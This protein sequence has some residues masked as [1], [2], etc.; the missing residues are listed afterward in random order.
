MTFYLKIPFIF[1]IFVFTL[2]MQNTKAQEIAVTLRGDSIV[3]FANGTW[4]FLDNYQRGLGNA[5]EDIPFND[6]I[7]TTPSKSTRK[8]NGF[9]NLYE[10]W[11]DNNKWQRLTPAEINAEADIALKLLDGDVYAMILF[12]EMEIPVEN[13]ANIAVSNAVAAAPDVVVTGKEYRKVNDNTVIWMRMEG[14]PQGMKIVYYSY[15]CSNSK[16]SLQFV[17]FTGQNI[18]DRYQ[19]DIEDLLNGLVFSEI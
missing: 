1:T 5:K 17:T 14:S 18:I 3:L 10:V 12:E 13:L 8:I 16:G 15:Y 19:K 9:D 6:Q 7:F 11:Y 2:G 4:D